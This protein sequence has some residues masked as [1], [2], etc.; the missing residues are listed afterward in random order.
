MT[1]TIATSRHTKR[2]DRRALVEAGKRYH[3]AK[4]AYLYM[5][6]S[7][8]L[9]YEYHAARAAFVHA[10]ECYAVGRR[11]ASVEFGLAHYARTKKAA[12]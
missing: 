2:A 7:E 5:P 1:D 9:F 8:G 6:F 12:Q 3:A 11:R 4:L 10:A